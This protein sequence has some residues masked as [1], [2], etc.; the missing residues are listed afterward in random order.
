MEIK[1]TPKEEVKEGPVALIYFTH[2]VFKG[3]D[4]EAVYLTGPYSQSLPSGTALTHSS[5]TF[6]S[7]LELEGEFSEEDYT[8]IYKGDSVTIT[9]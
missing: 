2:L 6:E 5:E 1:Y 4:G 9:F 8:P 3:E 7:L